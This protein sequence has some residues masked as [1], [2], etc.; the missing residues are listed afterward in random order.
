M[1]TLFFAWEDRKVLQSN[2]D[3]KIRLD[4]KT[5]SDKKFPNLIDKCNKERLYNVI[6]LNKT[7]LDYLDKLNQ[8]CL[9]V[10]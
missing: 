8:H 7:N 10:L 6:N 3:K 1:S 4:K 9:R 2:L 5:L